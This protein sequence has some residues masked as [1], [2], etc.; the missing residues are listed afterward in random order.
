M[1]KKNIKI[2]S[3]IFIL[4][5]SIINIFAF[6]AELKVDKN[7]SNINENINLRIEIKSST[8]WEVKITDI[9]WLENFEKIW[10]SQSQSSSTQVMINNWKT[11]TQTNK[12]VN[13]DLILK[14]KKKWEFKLWPAILESGNEKKESNS[15]KIKIDWTD[16]SIINKDSPI[17]PF[18]KGDENKKTEEENNENKDKNIEN[19]KEQKSENWNSNIEN[20]KNLKN[21]NYSLYLLI[22]VLISSWLLFYL[23]MKRKNIF[24]EEKD[25]S[26]QQGGFIPLQNKK[27]II[28]PEIW[29]ENFINKITNIFKE[30]LSN[31]FN[32]ENIENLTFDEIF[33]TI[34]KDSNIEKIIKKINKAKYSNIDENNEEILE[35]IKDF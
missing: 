14:A 32:I 30:K 5:T 3:I 11:E 8:W 2:F 27:E 34:W 7:N 1:N 20:N 18:N 33:V 23:L 6:E 24:L 28:Y 10:Q 25:S 22:F 35:L 16:I 15:V 26:E 4:F 13:L 29:E 12:T 31:K 17:I 21:N 19:K 9:K